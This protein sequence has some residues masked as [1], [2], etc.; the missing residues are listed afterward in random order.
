M[1]SYGQTRDGR[2]HPCDQ[3]LA[4]PRAA[5]CA[6]APISPTMVTGGKS[7][8]GR[9]VVVNGLLYGSIA[10][11]ASINGVSAKCM[12]EALSKG[13]TTY[14]GMSVRYAEEGEL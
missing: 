2:R 13:A 1:I 14:A 11:A 3:P 6:K 8:N 9:A 7:R 5:R 12:R 10:D 4:E